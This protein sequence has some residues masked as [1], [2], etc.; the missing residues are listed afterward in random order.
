MVS[1]TLQHPQITLSGPVLPVTLIK[2]GTQLSTNSSSCQAIPVLIDTGASHSFILQGIPAQLGLN[3]K[4]TIMI[5]GPTMA[6]LQCNQYDIEIIFPNNQN[7]IIRVVE[8]PVITPA[9]IQCVLGRDFL[10]D[11]IFIYN[12]KENF[13]TL[14]F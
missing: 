13:F 7:I 12:G 14:V 3:H 6:N 10:K 1:F 8:V 2:P 9:P 5:N 4:G 11:S